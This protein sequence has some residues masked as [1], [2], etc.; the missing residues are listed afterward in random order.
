MILLAAV[1]AGMASGIALGYYHVAWNRMIAAGGDGYW[2]RTVPIWQL[3]VAIALGVTALGLLLAWCV[4]R[5]PRD[6]VRRYAD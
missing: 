4:T 1:P 3:Q 5:P 2:L 6:L